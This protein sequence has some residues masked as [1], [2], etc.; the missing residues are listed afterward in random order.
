[1][2][3]AAFRE[4]HVTWH[5]C[6]IKF[7]RWWIKT[8]SKCPLN[9]QSKCQFSL[10]IKIFNSW[11][12][13]SIPVFNL[14]LYVAPLLAIPHGAMCNITRRFVSNRF[15]K[16]Y[17]SFAHGRNCHSRN[18]RCTFYKFPH[19]KNSSRLL[20]STMQR[21]YYFQIVCSNFDLKCA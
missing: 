13:F 11:I 16:K 12:T 19:N 20:S 15:S 17:L 10:S 4:Y 5:Q 7:R 8:Y 1:M 3:L 18:I 14:C 2:R 9:V 6:V 21:I